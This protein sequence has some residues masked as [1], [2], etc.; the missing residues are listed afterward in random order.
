[1]KFNIV[2]LS[3]PFQKRNPVHGTDIT[4]KLEYIAKPINKKFKPAYVYSVDIN[5]INDIID[6]INKTGQDIQFT[7]TADYNL[8][9]TDIYDKPTAIYEY[10]IEIND[11]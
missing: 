2:T 8:K 7:K 6:M 4:V 1:M 5:S 3:D 11:L 9:T 10:T